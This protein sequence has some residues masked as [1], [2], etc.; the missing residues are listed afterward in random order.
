MTAALVYKEIRENAWIGAVGLVAMLVVALTAMGHS[1]LPMVL[2]ESRYGVIPFLSD[3]FGMQ[4]GLVAFLLAM[5]LGFRQSLGDFVGDA[6]LFLLHRPVSRRHIFATKLAIGLGLYL[7]CGAAA[8]VLYAA[9]AAT[10]GNHASP[11]AWSMTAG[12]WMTWLSMTAVYLGA[13][14]AGIRPAAWWGTRLAP[15]ACGALV[16]FLLAMPLP[17][18]ASLAVLAI[19]DTLLVASI[20]WVVQT[21]EFA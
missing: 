10:P 5:A 3:T 12:A 9:W 2:G 1:P 16:A 19:A 6:H 7:L 20:F 8:I 18:L 15:L 21:R 13:L 14:L 11:F 17:W 4:F